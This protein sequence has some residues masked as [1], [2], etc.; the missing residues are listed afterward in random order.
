MKCYA[1]LQWQ[2]ALFSNSKMGKKCLIWVDK[3]IFRPFFR[4][5]PSGK[6]ADA[7]LTIYDFWAILVPNSHSIGLF[8]SSL[9]IKLDNFYPS[10]HKRLWWNMTYYNTPILF[11][12]KRKKIYI[13]LR[14][15]LPKKTVHSFWKWHLF[16]CC[17][18][19]TYAYLKKGRLVRFFK[20]IWIWM[21]IY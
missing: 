4:K 11:I 2:V 7:F 21:K 17:V 5:C 6:G 13:L 3:S 15:S 1:N 8:Y 16:F 12:S 19:E 20:V 18:R 14:N 10:K 9:E